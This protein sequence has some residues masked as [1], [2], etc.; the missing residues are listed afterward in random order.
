[1]SDSRSYFL[2]ARG[3]G[4]LQ[5]HVALLGELESIGKQVH[6][7]LLQALVISEHGR[8][9]IFTG[10]NEEAKMFVLSELMEAAFQLGRDFVDGNI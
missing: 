7:Y 6:Q 10:L 9:E 4:D 2:I 1:L 5:D 3:R 8:T